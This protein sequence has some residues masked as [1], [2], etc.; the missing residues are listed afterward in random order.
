LT[1]FDSH[2]TGWAGHEKIRVYRFRESLGG[3]EIKGI[4]RER[5]NPADSLRTAGPQKWYGSELDYL[6]S[7]QAFRGVNKIKL[8]LLTVCQGFVSLSLN[9]GKMDKDVLPRI[10]LNKTKP[11]A[12]IKPLYLTPHHTYHSF[13]TR[14]KSV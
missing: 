13:L 5:K 14:L 10:L 11:L 2:K 4:H 1:S 9:S 6:G 3:E 8:Y 12:V 7:L